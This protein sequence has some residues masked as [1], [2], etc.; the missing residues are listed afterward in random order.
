MICS[1]VIVFLY[2]LLLLILFVS[3]FSQRSTFFLPAAS[4]LDMDPD[5]HVGYT[6]NAGGRGTLDLL[7]SCI[8]T[9][10]L[11]TW[12]IQRLQVIP[13]S[14][15]KTIIFRKKTLWMLNTL[16]CPEY[17]TW[18]A[19]LQ[20]QRARKYREVC[21]LGHKDWTMQ[22]GFY[23]DMGGFQVTLEGA[24]PGLQF[25]KGNGD[26]LEL[27]D[28]VRITIRL[29]DLILLMRADL[30]PLPNIHIRDLEERSK[31]DQFARFITALQ[32]LHF[33]VHSVGRLASNLPIS[34][35]EV[36][37][38]AF[39]CCAAFVEYFWWNK[40]L[41]LRT[42]TVTTLSPDKHVHFISILPRLRFNTPEQDLAETRSFKLFFDRILRD[43]MRR[44]IIHVVWIGC[45]FNGIHVLAWNF[46][47]AS[48]TERLLWQITS[49]GACGS[50][51]L[52]WAVTFLRSKVPRLVLLGL[53]SIYCICR[54]YLIVEVFV[55]LRSVPEALYSSAA[56]QN[57]FPGV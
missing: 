23:V 5:R 16:L 17:V 39:V 50:I 53:C 49:I 52:A 22:H 28:G 29:D 1:Y 42:A 3:H 41:D 45:I 43:E 37:T 56:W 21:M 13:W 57:I 31:N 40:P 10:A 9:I 14:V 20:W 27:D 46:F 18:I 32:V 47:F 44:S 15:S 24:S 51:V 34:T 4:F 6:I 2:H 11:C 38:L 19:F 12:T 35:L 25:G 48:E 55:G 33:V 54:I 36:S 30:L 7:W 26:I 8:I